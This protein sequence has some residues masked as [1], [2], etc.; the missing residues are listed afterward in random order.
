MVDVFDRL[1]GYQADAPALIAHGVVEHVIRFV[2]G[3]VDERDL[4]GVFLVEARRITAA[5]V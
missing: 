3:I 1:V 4:M 5:S 2:L